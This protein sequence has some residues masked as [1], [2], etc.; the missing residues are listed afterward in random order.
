MEL[1]LQRRPRQDDCTIGDLCG[2][3]QDHYFNY[4][5]LEPG[6]GG[7][8]PIPAGIYDII[9]DWSDRF[10]RPMPHILH[11]QGF[12]GIRIHIGNYPTDTEGCILIGK[13]A[14]QSSI[15]DSGV[16]FITFYE[17]IDNLIEMGENVTLNIKDDEKD[18]LLIKT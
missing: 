4:S 16:A 11:V 5:T 13:S 14:N 9:V 7:K 8:G 12:D 18:I 1:T 3:Y 2:N 15:N 10:L 6:R 17:M